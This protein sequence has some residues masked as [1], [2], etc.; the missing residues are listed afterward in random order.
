MTI[1]DETMSD[2]QE[3]FGA[4]EISF[5]IGDD[6]QDND[7]EED[8]GEHTETEATETNNRPPARG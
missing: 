4:V 7:D 2:A 3:G 8:E 5:T 1:T 6:S